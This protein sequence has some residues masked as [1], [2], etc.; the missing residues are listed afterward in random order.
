MSALLRSNILKSKR[1]FTLVELIVTITIIAVLSAVALTTYSSAQTKA[2]DHRRKQDIKSIQTALE[3]YYSVNKKYPSSTG[4]YLSDNTSTWLPGLDTTY[5]NQVPND[6][7]KNGQNPVL[8]SGALGY[9]FRSGP[10]NGGS[11]SGISGTDQYYILATGLED[12]ND[13]ERN[14]IKQYKDCNNDTPTNPDA[15]VVFSNQ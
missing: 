10:I 12:K 11:C 3:L 14:A 8:T 4:W 15:Y 1:G 9:A 6:P 2:R 5:I 7:K 13:G